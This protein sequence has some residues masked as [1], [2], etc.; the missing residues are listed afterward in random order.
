MPS[1]ADARDQAGERHQQRRRA[2]GRVEQPGVGRRELAAVGVAAGGREQ[3]VDLAL[4]EE[5]EPVSSTNATGFR[6]NWLS[7][8][9]PT[10][11][12]ANAMN[13][14]FSRPIRSETQPKNG[15]LTPLSTR[16]I[17]SANVSAGS[18]RPSSDTG[19]VGDAEILGDRRELR[20]GHEAAR[21]REHE[22]HVHHPERR[23]AQHLERRVLARIDGSR[24]AHRRDARRRELR[25]GRPQEP[26][27]RGTPPRPARC[28]T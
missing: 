14:V 27:E 19:D 15:R 4:G 9:M 25:V 1:A 7:S 18:V 3:A 5:H 28:R 11:S 10:P 6:P 8:R 17:D 2:L 16:S 12:S 24:A 22:H 21:G 13:I 20:G 26:A 23:R